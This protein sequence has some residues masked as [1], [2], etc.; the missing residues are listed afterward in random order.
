M[1]PVLNTQS[2]NLWILVGYIFLPPLSLN[3]P[4]M[5]EI[6]QRLVIPY[7]VFVVTDASEKYKTYCTAN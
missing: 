1:Y 6:R 4:Y 2:V 5:L 7:L 3:I